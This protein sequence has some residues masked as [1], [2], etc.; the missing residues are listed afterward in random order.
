MK[1]TL[2]TIGLLCMAYSGIAQEKKEKKEK[3]KGGFFDN[4]EVKKSF[5][6]DI[7]KEKPAVASF[8]I[9]GNE[10]NYFT[11]NGGVAFRNY[12]LTSTSKINLDVWGL[13]NRNNQI[14]KEQKNYKLGTTVEWYK[15]YYKA[16]KI[17]P[18]DF[19]FKVNWSNEYQR[20]SIDTVSS[21]LSLL[22]FSP[23]FSISK[24]WKGEWTALAW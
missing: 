1:N 20:N 16:D 5:E 8:T 19:A 11:I 12:L 23:F 18:G 7:D 21:Y 15:L 9:P 13:Y 24:N 6:N 3:S 4:F 17:T 2:I 22:Y 14:D 10:N